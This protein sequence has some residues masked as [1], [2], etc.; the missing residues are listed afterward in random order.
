MPWTGQRR[1][2][3][4]AITPPA[5]RKPEGDYAVI[6]S[7]ANGEERASDNAVITQP[8]AKEREQGDYAVITETSSDAAPAPTGEAAHKRSARSQEEGAQEPDPQLLQSLPWHDVA[9]I[10]DIIFTHMPEADVK[11]LNNALGARYGG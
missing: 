3:L 6:T 11:R 1:S 9:S 5:P 4:P 10:A 8:A 7:Q 2:Q